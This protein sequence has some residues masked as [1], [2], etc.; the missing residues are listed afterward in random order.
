MPAENIFKPGDKAPR[1]GEYEVV[2][3]DS[4][5]PGKEQRVV[6]VKEGERFPPTP[7]EGLGYKMHVATERGGRGQ[8]Q[9][10]GQ[11]QGRGG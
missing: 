2:E 3:M 5:R 1:S 9:I 11:G 10:Q 6:T 8:G 4:G 7:T